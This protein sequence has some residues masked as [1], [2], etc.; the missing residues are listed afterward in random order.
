MKILVADDHDLV[1][2][3][4]ALFLQN[5]GGIEVTVAATLDEAM[6]RIDEAGSFDLVLLDYGM[7]GMDGLAGLKRAIAAN[8]DKPVAL[9]SGVA[10]RT[11]AEDAL[12]AGAAGFVP[13]TLGAKSMVNALR[14]MASGEQYAPVEWMT[15]M[16]AEASHPLA[17]KLSAREMQV[18]EGLCDGKANKEIARDLDL[19]EVTVKLHVKTLSRKLDARNRTHAAMIARDAKL[20][21]Q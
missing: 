5:E 17:D 19:Q 16:E 3:T 1:R 12:A 11:V 2:D 15:E 9:M 6:V 4:I 7:P 10:S 13:K 21:E 18:L 14:F 20:F 8:Q